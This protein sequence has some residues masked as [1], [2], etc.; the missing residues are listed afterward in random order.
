MKENPKD[1]LESMADEGLDER[2]AED[3]LK[4]LAD[5]NRKNP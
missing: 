3:L 1:I 5:F 2:A 4:Q